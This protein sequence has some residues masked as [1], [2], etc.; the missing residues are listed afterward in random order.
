MS[1][2]GTADRH[3]T[4]FSRAFE[5][6]SDAYLTTEALNDAQ[7][8]VRWGFSTQIPRPFNVMSLFVS[9]DDLIGKDFEEG[10]ASLKEILERKG[11]DAR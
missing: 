8:K 7:T 4:S 11:E 10:L 9:M 2:G 5:S 6:S 1:F 3:P